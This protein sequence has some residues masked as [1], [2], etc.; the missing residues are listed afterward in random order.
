MS[1]K[2][3]VRASWKRDYPKDKAVRA[4]LSRRICEHIATS[5]EFQK[6]KH[7]GIYAAQPWEADLSDL[8]RL[9]PDAC[10]FPVTL[11]MT[12][13]L[14]FFSVLRLEHLNTGFAGIKEPQREPSRKVFWR[15]GDLVLV[16]G[17]AFDRYGGRVGSGAGFYDRFLANKP[18]LKWGV[19]FEAQLHEKLAQESTDV[20]MD[21][22]VTEHGWG[23]IE[24]P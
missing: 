23:A 4:E 20:R 2:A 9:R 18:V 10:V 13:E 7:V 22:L 14:V 5:P 12:K 8:W 21:G 6:A 24:P 15:P 11:N 17:V 19:A 16:P 3:E 1:S